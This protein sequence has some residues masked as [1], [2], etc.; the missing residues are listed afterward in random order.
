MSTPVESGSCGDVFVYCLF[1]PCLEAGRTG[2]FV[3]VPGCSVNKQADRMWF[4]GQAGK[5]DSWN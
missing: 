4:L 1:R 5:P 2:H 3:S